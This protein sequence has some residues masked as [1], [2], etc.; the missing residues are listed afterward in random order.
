MP[1]D[2]QRE[3]VDLIVVGASV[4]GL[5]AAITAADQGLRAIVVERTKEPG[6]GA[7]SE[8]ERIA[9]AGTAQQ[10][11]AGIDDSAERLV[12]DVVGAALHR[13]DVE[14]VEALAAQGP[15]LLEW[16]DGRCGVASTLAARYAAPGH[17]APRLHLPGDRGGVDLVEALVRVAHRATRVGIRFGT[18]ADRLLHDDGGVRG[19]RVKF[20]RKEQELH[21]PVL[22]ACGGFAASDPLVAEHCPDIAA[23]PYVGPASADGEALRLGAQ[24]GAQTRRLSAARITPHFALPTN[25]AVTAPLVELGAILL[26]QLGRRFVDETQP[27]LVVAKAVRAQPGKV[28]YLLFDERI[29]AIA[30]EADPYFARVVLPRA[31]RHA[32]LLAD[33]GRQFGIP[34]EA[35]P[36]AVATYDANRDLGG[37]PFGRAGGVAL[38]E[39]FHAIR[40]TAIRRRT[41]GGL[42][43]DATARVLSAAGAPIPHLYA[44]GAAAAGIAGESTDGALDGTD[45][46]TALGLGRLAALDVIAQRTRHAAEPP[47]PDDTPA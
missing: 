20:G 39:P 12:H 34:E 36:Q 40:V 1:S 32:S 30:R 11:A 15:A 43:I 6:G 14:V 42:A 16:L 37:D 41:L 27:A 45:A 23:L 5:L 47:P 2:P 38:T 9:A 4:G 10:R 46:L 3:T 29:V 35:L 26:N 25:L 44:C 33:L 22:L 7:G 17:S 31:A 18:T 13:V 8:P 21:G 19:V 24:V 28:A